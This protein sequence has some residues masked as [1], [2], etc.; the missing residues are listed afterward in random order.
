GKMNLIRYEGDEI[1][2]IY[3]EK[4]SQNGALSKKLHSLNQV[5]DHSSD[6]IFFI[7][8]N[9]E[10]NWANP[11]AYQKLG[12]KSFSNWDDLFLS[13][14]K[15]SAE[16]I[17]KASQLGN[18]TVSGAKMQSLDGRKLRV[19]VQIIEDTDQLYAVIREVTPDHSQSKNGQNA[20]NGVM[21]EHL[22][23]PFKPFEEMQREYIIDALR[24]CNWRIS[25]PKGAAKLLALNSRTLAS[26]MRRLGIYRKDFIE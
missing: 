25:G 21:D 2:C 4:A 24:Y 1:N 13:A 8:K 26:K 23:P 11:A 17:W 6:L 9:R 12:Y 3:A 5:L 16:N 10:I 18:F 14:P 19:E 20:S 22:D 7:G 15:L